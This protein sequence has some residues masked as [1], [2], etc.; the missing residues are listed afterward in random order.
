[1]RHS[2]AG[3][4]WNEL[5]GDVLRKHDLAQSKTVDAPLMQ[6]FQPPGAGPVSIWNE[7]GGPVR[8]FPPL[9]GAVA[10]PVDAW[11]RLGPKFAAL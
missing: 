8:P 4:R 9:H 10:D 6:T 3:Q 5:E 7:Y 2:G 11:P 1:M